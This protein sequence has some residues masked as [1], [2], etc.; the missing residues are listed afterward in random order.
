M[1]RTVARLAVGATAVALAL[2]ACAQGTGGGSDDGTGA[3]GDF[4]PEAELSGS[5]DVMGSAPAT[6]SPP[7]ASTG[8]RR[9]RRGR[10]G[11]ADRG[12]PRHPAVPLRRR[13]GA[14][15]RAHL[16]QPG[17]D[18]H[19]RLP[20]RIIPLTRCSA[21]AETCGPLVTD[22]RVMVCV[23]H[24]GELDGASFEN[25]LS[26]WPDGGGSLPRPAVVAW[27]ADGRKIGHA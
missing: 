3:G 26:H 12:R 2:G 16:R 17:P 7:P 25:R 14:A 10:R 22:E 20:R 23:Q 8:R 24:P 1:R 5:L 18:R 6:R 19:V 13:L 4:D 21:G 27:R 11:R 15:A 9:P